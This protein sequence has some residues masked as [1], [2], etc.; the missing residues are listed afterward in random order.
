MLLRWVEEVSLGDV[1]DPNP[2]GAIVTVERGILMK[3]LLGFAAAAALL[4]SPASKEAVSTKD[5]PLAA[6]PYSQAIKAGGFVFCGWSDLVIELE[7]D[8]HGHLEL[9]DLAVLDRPA[10]LDHLEPAHVVNRLASLGDCGLHRLC[11][12][13]G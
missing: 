10:L 4:G 7:A 9:G 3:N 8:A 11:E 13:G 12:A 5:A 2:R 6:G 1:V